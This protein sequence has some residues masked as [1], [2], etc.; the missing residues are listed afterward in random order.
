MREWIEEQVLWRDVER[1]CERPRQTLPG[2]GLLSANSAML[3]PI[4]S[5]EDRSARVQR[6]AGEMRFAGRQAILAE[7]ASTWR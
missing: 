1:L 3:M 7:M 5:S 4:Y 2:E 6:R